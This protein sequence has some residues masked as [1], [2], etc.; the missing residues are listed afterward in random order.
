MQLLL[1][2]ARGNTLK[3]YRTILQKI[4]EEPSVI[5]Q[6]HKAS[7]AGDSRAIVSLRPL[8]LCLQCPI[9]STEAERNQHIE[10]KGHVFCGYTPGMVASM[11]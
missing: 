1:S 5:T 10:A 3:N 11:G 6:T 9:I 4:Y 8:F 2:N 7:A